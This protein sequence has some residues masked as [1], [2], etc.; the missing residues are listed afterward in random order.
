MHVLCWDTL[1]ILTA[2]GPQIR[3]SDHF[4]LCIANVLGL[5]RLSRML[6]SSSIVSVKVR[7]L[8]SGYSQGFCS[9]LARRV[10]L[11]TPSWGSDMRVHMVVA[12]TIHHGLHGLK[13]LQAS[14]SQP[15][16]RHALHIVLSCMKVQRYAAQKFQKHANE[17]AIFRI[18]HNGL[19]RLWSSHKFRRQTLIAAF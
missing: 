9:G 5:T 18:S 13:V 11:R 10:Q 8:S 12:N 3:N 1:A 4:G 15:C 7:F 2:L 19:V 14:H 17:D 6:G 16:V